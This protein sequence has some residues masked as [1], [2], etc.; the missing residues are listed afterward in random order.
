MRFG[1]ELERARTTCSLCDSLHVDNMKR[2][3]CGRPMRIV[4]GVSCGCLVDIKTTLVTEH[5]PQGKW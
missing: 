5:C 3:W 2:R 4:D 1:E